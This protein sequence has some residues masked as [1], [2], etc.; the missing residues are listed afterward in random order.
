MS[1]LHHRIVI[2]GAGG[3][4]RAVGLLLAEWGE[5]D[6]E[7]RIGDAVAENARDAAEW[8]RAGTTRSDRR[9]PV[10]AFTMPPAG[11]DDELDRALAD[12]DALLD[13]LPWTEAV[14]MAG[15]ARDHGLCYANLT[16][17]VESSERIARLAEG[18]ERGFVLQTGLAPGFVDVLGHELFRD[19][20]RRHGV[21]RVES[22]RLRVGALPVRA[23]PPHYYGF[24]W[25]PRG[26]ATEYLEP[27][28]VLRDGELATRDS[29]TGIETVRLGDLTLE[30]ALTSGGA[31]DLPDHLAGRVRDLDYK[32]LRHPGHWAWVERTLAALPDGDVEAPIAALEEEMLRRIPHVDDDQVVIYAAVEGHDRAGVRRRQDELLVIR[33]RTV[34]RHRLKAIQ[35]TT[36]AALAESLHM[37]L[38]DGFSGVVLQSSI[39]PGRWL[40]GPYVR[41]SYY[42]DD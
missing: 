13:C 34:G 21:D 18:A 16:E 33:P 41:K 20:C 6:V 38:A 15:L 37:L 9:V 8:V 5:G 39:E 40:A 36:A 14:R 31:A 29:L 10:H 24:T 42:G 4:G 35:H 12:A 23:L 27:S 25:N 28:V 30:E 3:I 7:V 19:F 17:H 1:N 22:L 2:A 32:T 11:S 26:V